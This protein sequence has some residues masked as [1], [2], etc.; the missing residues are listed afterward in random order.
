[1]AS[2]TPEQDAGGQPSAA[3]AES[4][5]P[6]VLLIG[7]SISC[8]YTEPVKAPLKDI[9]NIHRPDTNCAATTAGIA[10]I[11]SWLGPKEWD[12]IQFNWGLHDLCYRH[13]DSKVYGNRDKV[14]GTLSVEPEA[15][16]ANLEH[17]VNVMAK[18]AR[19]LVWASTTFVPEGEVGRHQGDEV[20]YNALAVEIMARHGIATDDLHRVTQAFAPSMF[21]CPGDVHYSEEGSAAIAKAVAECI[22]EQLTRQA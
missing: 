19:R 10:N 4:G 21:T 22:K 5:L 2:H 16:A 7:D 15:Y 11:D 9:C 13:P 1:M 8:G 20:R 6:E 17:L 3:P 18:R 12:L 14:N